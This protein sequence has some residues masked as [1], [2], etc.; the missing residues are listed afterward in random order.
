ML[1]HSVFRY[2]HHRLYRLQVLTL[3]YILNF[4]QVLHHIIHL[5]FLLVEV[6]KKLVSQIFVKRLV[7]LALDLTFGCQLL[8][9]SH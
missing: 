2:I 6:V 8:I 5:L 3:D 7:L 9:L 4:C 1:G